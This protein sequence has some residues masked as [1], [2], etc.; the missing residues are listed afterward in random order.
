MTSI[1]RKTRPGLL[2][3]AALLAAFTCTGVAH[4][5][6]SS[7]GEEFLST[8]DAVP[9]NV[10]FLL[11]LSSASSDDCGEHGDSGDTASMGSTSGT[12][13]LAA[14]LDAV[15]KLTRH[16]DWANYGV[17]GTT[18]SSSD[19]GFYEIAPL[20][21]SHAEI[22]TA[23]AS[24]TAHGGTTRNLGEALASLSTSYFNISTTSTSTAS[25][26]NAPIEYWCQE[27]HVITIAMEYGQNDDN[28]S[29]YSS[30]MSNDISCNSFG[31]IN[32]TETSCYYDNVVAALYNKDH[33]SDLSGDQTVTTHTVG[34]KVRSASMAELLFGNSVDEINNDGTY[35][36]ANDGDEILG[37][38]VTVMAQI[39]T[40]F[41]SRSAPVVSA[42]GAYLVY[43]FY[44]VVGRGTD[45]QGNH[46]KLAQG[47]VRAYEIGNDPTDTSTYGVVQYNGDSQFGGALWDAGDLLV[48]RPV[49]AS[50][51][52]KDDRDGLGQRDIYTF[53]P[54]MMALTG[55]AL[56]QEAISDLRMGFDYEFAQA[57]VGNTSTLDYFLDTATDSNLCGTD[58]AYDLNGDCLVNPDDMQALI[59]FTRGLPSATF[60]YLT[61]ERGYWKLGDAPHSVPVV[62]TA[63][64]NSFTSDNTYRTFISDLVSAGVPDI[65]ISAANDG[66][67]HAFRLED[68]PTTICTTYSSGLGSDEDCD[69]AGEELWAWI[70]SY[71]LYR[72]PGEDWSGRLI[73]LMW[74]GRTFLFDGSPVVEDVW[75]DADDD[76]IK[77]SD[78]SEWRRVVVVQQGQGGPVT[79]ALDITDSQ[80]P[81]FLWEQM[82]TSDYSAMGY[83]VA[84]P[85]VANV[86]D[87]EDPTDPRDRWVAMWS[88]GR[89]VPYSSA[90]KFYYKTAEP[91][92][93]MWHVADDY[94]GTS[95]KTFAESGSSIG[96]QHP[97]YSD[98]GSS[99]DGDGDG[100]YEYAYISGSLA[101]IDVDSDGDVDV[102]YFPVTVSYEP[103]DMGDPDGDGT[104]GLSDPTEPGN[105]WIYKAI[106]DTTD[107]DDPTWC[108]FYDPYDSVSVRPEV[109]Y[110]VT[111][112]W[113]TDGALGLYWG[114]G[115]PY[116]RTSTDTGYFFAMKDETPLACN[117]ASPISNCGTDGVVELD[118]GE[119]LTGNPLVYAGSVYFST[120]LPDSSDP[121]CTAGTGRIYALSFDDCSDNT[122]SDGD[123]DTTDDPAYIE[124]DGYPSSLTVS[125]QG[126]I[127]YGTSAPDTTQSG[128]AAVGEITGAADPFMGT[129]TM[130]LR[131]IY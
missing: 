40:G 118:A 46:G 101:A 71:V 39:R 34:V 58:D 29:T 37:S 12:T 69:E 31:S 47:H 131:E 82:N 67:L 80:S 18:S 106:I 122:D 53:V 28:P 93:Y 42:D 97:G 121:Y 22:S 70:P 86:Y 107:P 24:V 113:H 15:D 38:L 123:G 19:D 95:A 90:N 129:R 83:S 110:A 62:V 126:T 23:L 102:L 78:G 124:V 56:Y 7:A 5:G 59:D 41:Y 11:D 20:G 112:A 52:Q 1:F 60:R 14:M 2:G 117:G 130:G 3:G 100:T 21:S 25:F 33:R 79:L 98:H 109:Y 44:E 127:F 27:N 61:E 87:A 89:A 111:A 96:S 81:T 54:E 75:I 72:D 108:E 74:Y 114:S 84:S 77:A 73:D 120:Y 36:V 8:F 30:S 91:N 105:T 66:M 76:G 115:T 55:T 63:R 116:S 88:S 104:T 92:L 57:L 48:S 68:D 32:S 35:I 99:L 94:W 85:V 13:C 103:V 119:G 16:F 45:I 125:E 128:A 49:V 4:A 9:P 43:S 65:V 64:N 26:S 50:E 17:V 10:V 6:S 51:S